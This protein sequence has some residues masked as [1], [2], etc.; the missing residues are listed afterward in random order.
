M[1]ITNSGLRFGRIVV[2]VLVADTNTHMYM[3]LEPSF[4]RCRSALLSFSCCKLG[5]KAAA[6]AL[7]VVGLLGHQ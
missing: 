7:E 4:R 2:V 1:S 3:G 5:P 6:A